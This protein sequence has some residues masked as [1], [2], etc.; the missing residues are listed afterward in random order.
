MPRKTKNSKKDQ[1][2]DQEDFEPQV[3]FTVINI[4]TPPPGDI[5]PPEK[6]PPLMEVENNNTELV[7]PKI[8]FRYNKIDRDVNTLSDLIEILDVKRSTL[9]QRALV[10][11]LRELNSLIGMNTI[12]TQLTRQ[13][14]MLIQSLN[15]TGTFFHSVITGPPGTGKTTLIK[16]LANIYKN[17]GILSSNKVIKADRTTLI[18]EY[19]GHTAIKTKKVLDSA[20][21]GVLLIDEVY[22]LGSKS[23]SEDSFSKECIDTINQYLSEQVDS[24]ICIVCGYKDDIQK[25]FFARNEGLQRRFAWTFEI[26]S[27]STKELVEIFTKQCHDNQWSIDP[28]VTSSVLVD[29]FSKNDFEGNGGSTRNLLDRCKISYSARTFGKSIPKDIFKMLTHDD[30]VKGIELYNAT[31]MKHTCEYCSSKGT[32]KKNKCTKCASNLSLTGMYI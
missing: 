1:E 2:P 7:K 29:L 14:L 19:L 9:K 28:V 21:G 20:K 4:P 32:D 11:S 25:C 23:A 16:I 27:Y 24:L 17:L 31:K 30:I 26:D 18:G 15:D 12:K 13:L 6:T 10:E 8:K 5:P 22:S 3:F